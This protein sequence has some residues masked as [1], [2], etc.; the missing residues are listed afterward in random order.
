MTG[1]QKILA[2]VGPTASGK[3]DLA[4]DLARALDGEILSADMGQFYKK[5]DAATAKP[6]KDLGIPY[7]GIDLLAPEESSD[8]GSFARFADPVLADI[9]KRGKLPIL[10][11]GAGLYVRAL[12]EGLDAL[13][14]RDVEY[15]ESLKKRADEDGREI[16]HK[17]LEAIDPIAAKS[18]PVNNINRVS[19]ALEVHHLTGKPISSFWDREKRPPRHPAIYLG[20]E[21]DPEILRTRI[22][23]RAEAMFP[24]LLKEVRALVPDQ[25]MGIEPGFRCLGYPEAVACVR[26][27]LSQEDALEAMIK[28]TNAYAKRQ[29]TWFRRQVNTLWLKPGDSLAERA[30]RAYRDA[31]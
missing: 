11:G 6:E 17:E 19:R 9:R 5:L 16:L 18:I 3:T 20:I 25:Y 1:S 30:E 24:A 28:T 21:W 14:G 29:R 10:A 23:T 2:I 31:L 27:E 26:G 7:H 22:R 8:A 15:R 13:P 12:L 4:V